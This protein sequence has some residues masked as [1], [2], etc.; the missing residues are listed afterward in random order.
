M[1]AYQK[2]LELASN[3]FGKFLGV[4]IEQGKA[5]AFY[6]DGKEQVFITK[7][8]DYVDCIKSLYVYGETGQAPE[9]FLL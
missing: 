4:A 1:N 8:F 6:M 9:G 5:R 2:A 3:R 7:R